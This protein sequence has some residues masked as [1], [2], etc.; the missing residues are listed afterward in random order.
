M[1]SKIA[2]LICVTSCLAGCS[3]G[4]ASFR[5]VQLCLSNA[6]EVPA[7][8]T[9]MNTIAQDNRMQFTD[10]SGQAE[11]E[12]RSMTSVK[13]TVPHPLVVISAHRGDEV[14]FGAGNLGLP[15][16][17]MAIGFNGSDSNVARPFA[18]AVVSKLSR[19]WHVHEVP[20][21]RGALPLADCG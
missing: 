21:D 2:A 20:K 13:L 17:Q 19:R 5:T 3:Q 11:A 12:L 1:Q 14:S 7:F 4:Q 8:T 16:E 18:D 6:E 10:R 15:T 9:F